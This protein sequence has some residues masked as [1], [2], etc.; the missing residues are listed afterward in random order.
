VNQTEWWN[1]L[2]KMRIN[3]RNEMIE[4]WKE[5]NLFSF[6]WWLTLCLVIIFVW[7]WWKLVDYNRI[8]EIL[9]YGCLVSLFA[10]FLDV[11]GV[12]MVL[13]GYPNMLI[14]LVPPMIFIDFILLPIPFMFVYQYFE[15]SKPFVIAIIVLSALFA[16]VIEPLLVW[17]KI[18]SI[19]NWRYIYSF[20]I[21]IIMSLSMKWIITKLKIH[22]KGSL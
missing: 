20:P 12:S 1:A 17:F 5:V 21:Y 19:H 18:Y 8:I 4:Y 2:T 13:W 3:L 10:S 15:S 6:Q 14:P 9:L 16:F 11:V 22:H 7:T